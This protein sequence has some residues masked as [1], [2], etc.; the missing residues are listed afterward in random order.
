MGGW[1]AGRGQIAESIQTIGTT[2]SLTADQGFHLG[3]TMGKMGRFG[4]ARN[5]LLTVDDA[6][7]GYGQ[8]MS[9]V[10]N[11]VPKHPEIAV[12]ITVVRGCWRSRR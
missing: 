3:M 9:D 7:G 6:D 2:S 5:L 12:S 11:L 4:R 1:R 10:R 8:P